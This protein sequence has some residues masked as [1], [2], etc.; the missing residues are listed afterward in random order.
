GT[1]RGRDE[2]RAVERPR[3]RRRPSEPPGGPPRGADRLRVGHLAVGPDPHGQPARGVHDA[4]RRRGAARP[5]PR[6]RA[7]A[8]LGRLRPPAQGAGGHRRVVRQVRRHAA[9]GDPRPGR[10]ASFLGRPVHE[11]LPRVDVRPRHRDARRAP[12][13]A[14][15]LG[16]LQRR[17]PPGDGRAR[18]RVRHP[19]RAADGRPPRRAGR[20]APREVLPVQAV[21]RGVRQGRHVGRGVRRAGRHVQVP[22]RPRRDDEPRRRRADPRQARLE[23]RLADALA[24]RAGHVRAGGRGPPRA[25][26]QLHRRP[27]A[28]RARLRRARAGLGRLLVREDGRHG[29]EDVE[30]GGRRRRPRRR[31]ADPRARDRALDVHPAPAEPGL[32]DRPQARR[33]PAALRRVGRLRRACDRARPR[34]GRGGHAPPRDPHDGGRRRDVAPAGL[35]SAAVVRRRPDPGQPRADR[36]HRRVA[37]RRGGRPGRARAA[38]DLRDQ[39]RDRARRA[40]GSH[41]RARRLRRGGV[42]VARRADAR[43][44]R[45]PRRRPRRQLVDRRADDARLR[46]AQ[47][48]ARRRARRRPDARDQEGA[49]RV[50][51]GGLPP[52]RGQGEGPAH[53]DA[54]ALDRS[55]ARPRAAR[56]REHA[57]RV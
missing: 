15:P 50:L 21:L 23:G 41:R 22:P 18:A 20:G 24:P 45:A 5:R 36:A 34:R 56:C 37:P 1:S 16:R 43:G 19:R 31:A 12:V 6:R 27:L 38:P 9:G 42:G 57:R 3:R 46:G 25:A 53:P 51:Q 54:V 39:L 49:A 28:D 48:D 55:R 32:R 47:A 7:P 44:D 29:G 33:R 14:V 13:G 8:L 2:R 52:A 11:R 17:D 4:P 10:R 35:V 40:R 26:G 30:L